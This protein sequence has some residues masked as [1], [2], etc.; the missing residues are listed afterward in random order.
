M[1]R[2]KKA[3]IIIGGM[4]IL[5]VSIILYFSQYNIKGISHFMGITIDESVGKEY[6]GELGDYKVYTY[7]LV[8]D[9]RMFLSVSTGDGYSIKDA[10]EKNLV[11]LFDWKCFAKD[12]ATIGE[13]QIL[14]YE[15]Y[16]IIVADG[17]C[18]FTPLNA[19]YEDVLTE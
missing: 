9:D 3:A 8:S 1:K 15:N 16:Q 4:C 12:Q 19:N 7:H 18:I 10:L 13:V 6:Q 2:I 5:A 17:E 11:S 14:H